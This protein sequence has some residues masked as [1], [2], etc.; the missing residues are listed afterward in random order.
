MLEVM[1]N[2]V[3][4]VRPTRYPGEVGRWH[5][6]FQTTSLAR[7]GRHTAAN[8]F[9]T[10]ALA[11]GPSQL[12]NRLRYLRADLSLLPPARTKLGAEALVLIRDIT[13][14]FLEARYASYFSLPPL[15][16]C[17]AVQA[18]EEDAAAYFEDVFAPQFLGG[19]QLL[20]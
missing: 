15:Q 1:L 18:L 12:D 4:K 10:F 3:T 5:T 13:L 11:G 6:L 9:L 17:I 20:D 16:L 7:P 14:H 2:A 8:E 19:A